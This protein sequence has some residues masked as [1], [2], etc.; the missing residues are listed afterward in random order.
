MY[1]WAELVPS[2]ILITYIFMHSIK[3]KLSGIP[4]RYS[5]VNH[6]T[7]GLS[8]LDRTQ[9]YYLMMIVMCIV[10]GRRGGEIKTFTEKREND[11]LS[12]LIA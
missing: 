1:I 11:Y 2:I 12:F 8:S 9:P 5:K 4:H 7:L 10:L 6:A 3:K